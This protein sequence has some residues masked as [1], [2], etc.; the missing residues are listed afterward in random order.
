MIHRHVKRVL[1]LPEQDGRK[2][3]RVSYVIG[4]PG[5]KWMFDDDIS[6]V[7]L[8]I[9]LSKNYQGLNALL[10]TRSDLQADNDLMNE[11][12]V[13]ADMLHKLTN[14]QSYIWKE[15][16]RRYDMVH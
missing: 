2:R 1:P 4:M 3:S 16:E 7:P 12:R 10:K 15:L 9:Q 6:A 5:F 11:G 8:G 13:V 14:Y